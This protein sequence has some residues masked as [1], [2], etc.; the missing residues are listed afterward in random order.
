MPPPPPGSGGQLSQQAQLTNGHTLLAEHAQDHAPTLLSE[1]GLG[2]IPGF[3]V[4]VSLARVAVNASWD[5]VAKGMRPTRGN[6]NEMIQAQVL[7]TS[8]VGTCIVELRET[9]QKLLLIHRHF[10]NLVM[11]CSSTGFFKPVA[12]AIA[13]TFALRMKLLPFFKPRFALGRHRSAL[14]WLAFLTLKD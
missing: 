6:G 2:S 10:V 5:K 3:R 8:A 4:K 7:L 13:F 1:E 11:A 14:S 9:M 12:L